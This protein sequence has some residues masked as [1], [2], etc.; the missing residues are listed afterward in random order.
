MKSWGHT[1]TGEHFKFQQTHYVSMTYLFLNRLL[2]SSADGQISGV[3]L[4]S[5]AGIVD[6]DLSLIMTP[7]AGTGGR[8]VQLEMDAAVKGGVGRRAVL[9]TGRGLGHHHTVGVHFFSQ[10]KSLPTVPLV[11]LHWNMGKRL[12][13]GAGLQKYAHPLT[14]SG[15]ENWGVSQDPKPLACRTSHNS[16]S[17]DEFSLN[18]SNFL[19]VKF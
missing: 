16:T 13:T 7:A 11:C 19:I 5:N 1:E 17:C 15:Q 18:S 4:Q 6:A 2:I 12:L 14:Q 10:D 8:L 9:V 3:T